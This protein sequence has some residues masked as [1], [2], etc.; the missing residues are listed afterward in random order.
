MI[1]FR[2]N[3]DDERLAMREAFRNFL[4]AKGPDRRFLGGDQPNLA[5]LALYG[6]IN[7]FAGCSTFIEMRKDTDIGVW[8]D[9]M[10]NVVQSHQGSNLLKAKS[11]ALK[12]ASKK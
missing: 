12:A 7:S 11:D 8:F 1:N 10:Q 5:D 4:R 9:E 3:I 6:S 2:H